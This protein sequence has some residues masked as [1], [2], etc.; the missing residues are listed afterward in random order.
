MVAHYISP[1]PFVRHY[2]IKIQITSRTNQKTFFIFTIF[3]F[4]VSY[5]NHARELLHIKNKFILR[6]KNIQLLTKN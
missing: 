5:E 3:N 6:V 2:V 4:L 1:S